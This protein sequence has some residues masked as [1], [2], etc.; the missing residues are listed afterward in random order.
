MKICILGAGALGCALGAALTEGGSEVFL[1][2]RAKAH[3]DAMSA[4]GLIVRDTRGERSVPVKA[5]VDCSTLPIVDLVVVLVKSFDTRSAIADAKSILGA[6]T[7][8]L[9][10]QNGMGHEDI[11]A[12]A[13]GKSRVLAGKTYVGGVLLGPGHIVSESPGSAPMSAN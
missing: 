10:L 9:S 1:V 13:V 4:R 6:S 5:A 8:V 2:S 11:L 3:V 12:E 7:T